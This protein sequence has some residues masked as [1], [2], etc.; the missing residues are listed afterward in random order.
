MHARSPL[1]KPLLVAFP[2][3]FLVG[4]AGGALT[5][6]DAW[7]HALAKPPWQPP[8]IAF[9]IAWTTI[10][11]LCALAVALA[12]RARPEP[13]YRRTLLLACA[14]N[15]ALNVGWSWLFFWLRRPDWALVEVGLLWAS[16]VALIVVVGRAS[17][18]GAWLLAPYLAWVTI[19]ITLNGW[20]VYAN[21]PFG[22]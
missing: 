21:G 9:P 10:F 4:S 8:E 6:I 14:A 13:A 20:I 17:R 11:A 15:A 3:W 1:W 22:A 7:Y 2:A 5:P 16:I 19:A 12:W 18:P